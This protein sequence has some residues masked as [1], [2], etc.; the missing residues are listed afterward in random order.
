MEKAYQLRFRHLDGDVGPL[1]LE[2]ASS[3]AAMKA[4]IFQHWPTE[5]PLAA[6]VCS[7]SVIPHRIK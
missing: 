6:K 3:V 4:A 1:A 2:E 7:T 5:G